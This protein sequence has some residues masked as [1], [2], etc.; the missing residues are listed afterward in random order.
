MEHT[1][2]R[3]RKNQP[4]FLIFLSQTSNQ[5][6]INT[7]MADTDKNQPAF[8]ISLIRIIKVMCKEKPD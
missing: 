8:L 1:D 3:H 2:G 7:Q 4:S 6:K 5:N